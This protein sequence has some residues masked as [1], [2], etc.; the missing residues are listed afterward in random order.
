M[1]A[2][3]DARAWNKSVLAKSLK[4]ADLANWWALNGC[5]S[6]AVAP[7]QFNRSDLRWDAFD[8]RW[9]TNT[10]Y[11]KNLG[12][13]SNDFLRNLNR[14]ATYN[15]KLIAYWGLIDNS[16]VGNLLTLGDTGL[17]TV[18]GKL[19]PSAAKNATK[20]DAGLAILSVLHQRLMDNK[21]TGPIQ[22]PQNDGLV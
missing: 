9:D 3:G 5:F 15:N 7:N 6:C 22:Y 14:Q 1:L 18:L 10:S 20:E 12:V 21:F 8:P 13:E 4:A 11:T 17:S 2:N 19:A 16:T